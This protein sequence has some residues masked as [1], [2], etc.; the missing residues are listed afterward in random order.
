MK[1]KEE[2][3]KKNNSRGLITIIVILVIVITGMGLYI[4]YDK[5]LVFSKIGQDE[6]NTNNIEDKSSSDNLNGQDDN[7]KE[8]DL[9]KSL[10]TTNITYSNPV[11]D[12]NGKYGLF[13]KINPDRKSV[14]LD[15][16]WITF[17]P[18]SGAST[19]ANNT[20]TYQITG[21]AKNIMDV[22]IGDLGQSSVG[23]TLFYL[24][25][26][27]TV[28]YTPMFNK[29]F[30]SQNNGYY[31]MNYTYDYSSDNRVTGQHFETKGAIADVVNVVQLYVVD[32][33]EGNIGGGHTTIGATKDGSF[34]DL[35]V[36]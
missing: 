15:I 35:I 36:D 17:G 9:N 31:E 19:W 23:I 11:K 10:N 30:D 28:E 33:M 1:E 12:T 18:L 22:F 26:D 3:V 6:K 32:A 5:K 16:N 4:A 7:V 14:S 27:G 8:L 29:M 20:E 24:M 13:M 34:Y 25:E 2:N 21:F